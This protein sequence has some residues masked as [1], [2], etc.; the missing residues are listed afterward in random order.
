MEKHPPYI[1]AILSFF[2]WVPFGQEFIDV[3]FS[4]KPS[5]LALSDKPFVGQ[6]PYC[7]GESVPIH[8]FFSLGI[9]KFNF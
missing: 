9:R 6:L 4:V 8:I 7:S 2:K 3:C 5:F 1:Y